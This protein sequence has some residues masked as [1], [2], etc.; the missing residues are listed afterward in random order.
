MKSFRWNPAKDEQLAPERGM[1]FE[2]IVVAVE[3]GGLLDILAHTNAGKCPRQRVLVVAHN[4]CVHLVPLVE[5]EDCCFLKTIIPSR[6]AT[7]DCLNAGDE[8]AHQD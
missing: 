4:H 7:R 3:P 2:G 6:K 8:S 1:S 5:E